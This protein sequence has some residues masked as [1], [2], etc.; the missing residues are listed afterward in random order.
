MKEQ[1]KQAIRFVERINA[2][3]QT[4]AEI[5]QGTGAVELM[6]SNTQSFTAQKWTKYRLAA[7]SEFFSYSYY[8]CEN[9]I[10]RFLLHMSPLIKPYESYTTIS[11][12]VTIAP[13]ITHIRTED[14]DEIKLN[15][16]FSEDWDFQLSLR[17]TQRE[18]KKYYIV[19]LLSEQGFVGKVDLRHDLIDFT[20]THKGIVAEYEKKFHKKIRSV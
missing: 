17:L 14:G 4:S 9:S 18:M 5:S 20:N 2:M 12:R 7:S 1:Y 13:Y 11:T 8:A 15:A 16:K 3:I 10:Q 19:S 6:R